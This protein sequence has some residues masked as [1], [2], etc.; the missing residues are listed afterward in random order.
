MKTCSPRPED[1]FEPC[2]HRPSPWVIQSSL[3]D[4]TFSCDEF[5]GFLED[6]SKFDL[7]PSV[8]SIAKKFLSFEKISF[9]E[10]EIYFFDGGMLPVPNR[11]LVGVHR[12][13]TRDYWWF[14]FDSLAFPVESM[15]EIAKV[16]QLVIDGRFRE[17]ARTPNSPGTTSKSPATLAVQVD[18]THALKHATDVAKSKGSSDYAGRTQVASGDLLDASNVIADVLNAQTSPAR[19]TNPS[20]IA[21]NEW[22]RARR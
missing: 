8:F 21:N 7:L 9:S 12:L 2:D 18:S 4:Q 22:W 1:K 3:S 10:F 19:P 14:S 5:F 13:N 11:T 16:T 20:T 17:R 15:R 6:F